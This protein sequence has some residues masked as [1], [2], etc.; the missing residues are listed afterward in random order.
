MP[1]RCL[2]RSC[3]SAHQ[4]SKFPVVDLGFFG[5]VAS[6]L[7]DPLSSFRSLNLEDSGQHRI[8]NL[9]LFV[10]EIVEVLLDEVVDEISYSLAFITIGTFRSHVKGAEFGFGLKF[11]N[12]FLHLNTDCS[13]EAVSDINSFKALLK[14]LRIVLAM[15]SRKRLIGSALMCMAVYKRIIF[16]PR[17]VCGVKASL[18]HCPEDG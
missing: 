5:A 10:E 8:G 9:R 13:N 17:L 6:K 11:K 18:Y 4:Q 12:R 3:P 1:K 15:P 16:L 7:L 14:K 2:F